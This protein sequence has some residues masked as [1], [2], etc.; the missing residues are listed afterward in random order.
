MNSESDPLA[1]DRP[2]IR[3][4]QFLKWQ[5]IVGTGG[6]AKFMIQEGY[7]IVNGEIEY[8]RGRKIYPEDVIELTEDSPLGEGSW[9]C[10]PLEK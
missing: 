7:L 2:S 6:Q 10:P 3:L 5:G 9:V 8:R 4:D 1:A